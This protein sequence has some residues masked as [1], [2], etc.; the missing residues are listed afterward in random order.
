M[1]DR[2]PKIWHDEI[3]TTISHKCVAKKLQH[4]GHA[5]QCVFEWVD[6]LGRVD[7]FHAL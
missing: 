7:M 1:V 2:I 4:S 5:I 6:A 3:N